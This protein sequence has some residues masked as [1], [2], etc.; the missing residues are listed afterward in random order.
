[1]IIG[2]NRNTVIQ[3]IK[4]ACENR[5][6]YSKVE[7]NDPTLSKTESDRIVFGYAENRDTLPFKVKASVARRIADIATYALNRNTEIIGLEKLCDI[8]GGAIITSN[9]FSPIE[10]TGIRLAVKK[11]G[12]KRLNIVSQE[13]NLAMT[14]IIGFL[15]KYAD[16]IPISDNKDYLMHTF[17][18]ILSSLLQNKEF[19]LIYPEQEM[20][21]NYKK[22]R[23]PK[24]GAYYYAAKFSVPIISC[25]I[26]MTDTEELDTSEFR[27]VK[28]TVHILDVIKPNPSLSVKENSQIMLEKD[29]RL[30]TSAY[31]SFY[32]K[33][34]SYTFSCD[35]IGG[36]IGDGI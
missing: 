29:Y 27:K 20:W 26:T 36:W 7:T 19:V 8:D 18:E 2:E 21:F 23:P 11:A 32:G 6:F 31:E 17:P 1:M 35:D 34:L 13:T 33:Q 24:R 10:N 22:P 5:T 25:F 15:M 28:F 3:N 16:I 12:K 4:T 14:G 30:K 9:H